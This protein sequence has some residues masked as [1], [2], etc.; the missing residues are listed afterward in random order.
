MQLKGHPRLVQALSSLYSKLI[1]R[2]INPFTEILVTAG[3]FEAL[4]STIQG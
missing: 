4:Y 1:D 2:K 3:A